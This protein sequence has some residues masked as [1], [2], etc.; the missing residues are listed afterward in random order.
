M[1]VNLFDAN[2]Y[3]AANPDLVAAG[4]TT[5]DQL[6]S[7]FQV[8]GLVE[9]RSFSAFVNLN[10]YRA[11]NS[12]LARLDNRQLFDH[13]QQYGVAEGRRFSSFFDASFYRTSNSD[14]IN[15]DNTQLFEHLQKHGIAEGRRF[16]Q[17]A[18]LS[19][20]RNSNKDLAGFDNQQL[21]QHLQIHGLKENRQFSQFFDAKYYSANNSD[22]T[23]FDSERLL[24]H[25]EIYGLNESRKFSQTLDINYY[26]NLNSDL[27]TFNNKQLYE[28]FQLHG[29]NEGRV[30]SSMF[31]VKVYLANN[32]DLTA[33]GFSNQQA[34]THF[35]VLGQSE[36]RLGADYAG[37]TRDTGRI[38]TQNRGTISFSDYLDSSDSVDYYRIVLPYATN[39]T[40]K[41][42]NLNGNADLKIF[43]SNGNIVAN[44]SN[45]GSTAE[46]IDGTLGFGTYYVEVSSVNGANTFYNVTFSTVSPLSNATTLNI[47][48]STTGD[49]ST[50]QFQNFYR[51]NLN[52]STT[53]NAVLNGLS[54][55][56]NLKLIWD[57]NK[58]GEFDSEDESF[59]SDLQGVTSEQLK[60]LLPASNNYYI[61][62]GASSSS[63]VNYTLNLSTEQ[64]KALEYY[65]GSTLP[66]TAP[67]SSF[68]RFNGSSV[69]DG[70][71]TTNGDTTNLV[72]TMTG[73]AG[74]SGVYP[75]VEFNRSRGFSVRFQVKINS[76]SHAGDI[77]G[78][79]IADSA[80]FNL[81]AVTSD[82]KAIELGFWNNEIWAKDFNSGSSGGLLTHSTVER[83]THDTTILTN[84]ELSVLGN[85]YQLFANG[86]VVLT[87]K[88]RDYSALGGVYSIGSS[89]DS[90][91]DYLFLGDNSSFAKAAVDF[92][93]ISA[94]PE[95]TLLAS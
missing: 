92:K 56:G 91:N 79:S 4:I 50:T 10:F 57:I 18:D 42:D 33:A 48:S 44:S 47:N 64:S 58:N 62:V 45:T 94:T 12:D 38:V 85:T 86:N 2:Y 60:S 75:I 84:Y 69:Y 65:N 31:N 82:R 43:D 13:L 71:E 89:A 81:T 67:G 74:Y 28:H 87:G 51:F 77:N 29:L 21:L 70:T 88:L 26:R 76:E 1:T 90:E 7:H 80:G 5:N 25:F 9:G 14:L 32:S 3:K 83:A 61:W 11:S 6:L 23:G 95:P 37:N 24:E 68:L 73:T 20:Y 35:L 54:A 66:G 78:D 39:A 34:Y 46:T 27:Q 40:I 8:N 63:P 16:S 93:F 53:V 15:M 36:G 72:T 19:F 52:E 49:V 41:V 17:F 59:S 55:D 30:A 22:L